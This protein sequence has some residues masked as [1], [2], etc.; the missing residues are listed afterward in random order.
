M[1]PAVE[2]ATA[3]L[4]QYI[5]IVGA[6]EI[7]ELRALAHPLEGSTVDMVN[8][9]A[10]GGG[11]AELLA[12]LLPL[13]RELG[14][15]AHWRVMEGGPEFFEVT[16]AFHNALHGAAYHAKPKDFDIFLD[17]NQRNRQ[18]LALDARFMVI[19]IRSPPA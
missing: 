5:P 6:P 8:S 19:T 10:V 18:R 15:D 14:L 4:D 7:D 13:M 1:M 17:F 2:V 12:R 9:T 3:S 11:V 16:K